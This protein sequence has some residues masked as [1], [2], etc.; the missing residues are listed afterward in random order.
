MYNTQINVSLNTFFL[1]NVSYTIMRDIRVIIF[2][3]TT[4]NHDKISKINDYFEKIILNQFSNM[5]SC[6]SEKIQLKGG[7]FQALTDMYI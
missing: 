1:K 7:K 2:N 6:L 5:T 4:Y 3:I